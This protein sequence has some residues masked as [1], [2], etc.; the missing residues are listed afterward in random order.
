M[1][2]SKSF[3][4]SLNKKMLTQLRDS[5]T[6]LL[7]IHSYI[8]DQ[9]LKEDI[10]Y[11]SDSLRI[12]KLDPLEIKAL[13]NY[14]NLD[15]KRHIKEIGID[16][17]I[18]RFAKSLVVILNGSTFFILIDSDSA[19]NKSLRSALSELID[20]KRMEEYK[21]SAADND[22]KTQS[23]GSQDKSNALGF[24]IFISKVLPSYFRGD[25][26][27]KK[28]LYPFA[29][30]VFS[31]LEKGEI[32]VDQYGSP[33]L[34]DRIR[35]YGGLPDII[36]V[37]IDPNKLRA[38]NNKIIHIKSKNIKIS[39]ILGYIDLM[40]EHSEIDNQSLSGLLK[41]IDSVLEK[42]YKEYI[43]LRVD[44]LRG[45]KDIYNSAME[46]IKEIAS[47]ERALS[48]RDNIS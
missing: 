45:S 25:D 39:E 36:A 38:I 2:I 43:K 13:L 12:Y 11:Y 42:D 35:Q 3:N 31:S 7:E 15:K 24:S 29:V 32:R 1:E 14:K 37:D 44:K 41:K 10:I 8:I 23:S 33:D 21:K 18:T 22:N 26:V 47:L 27:F 5:L 28:L 30:Y 17:A 34:A 48:D 20:R 4:N 40:L 6:M 16:E 46:C 19:D 9:S